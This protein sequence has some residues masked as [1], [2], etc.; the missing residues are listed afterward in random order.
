[1][2]ALLFVLIGIE[3]LVVV[4]RA[5]IVAGLIV[6]PVVLVA[7]RVSVAGPIAILMAVRRAFSRARRGADVER[8]A[9]RHLGRAGAFGAGRRARDISSR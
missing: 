7:R 2:N 1:M 8:A 3:V 9:G 6:I 4:A 5:A